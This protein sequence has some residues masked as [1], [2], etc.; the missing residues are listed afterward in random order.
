MIFKKKFLGPLLSYAILV[1]LERY[2]VHKVRCKIELLHI[3]SEFSLVH[4][5]KECKKSLSLD[6]HLL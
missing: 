3:K 4:S 6:L 5:T 1:P 2:V